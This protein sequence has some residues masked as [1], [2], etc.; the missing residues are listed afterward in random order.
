MTQYNQSRTIS[1]YEI[2]FYCHFIF[3]FNFSWYPEVDAFFV[4]FVLLD[5]NGL[6]FT[7][8]YKYLIDLRMFCFISKH[9]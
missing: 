6:E 2:C 3:V 9:C 7:F 4:R 1:E 8:E 5:S